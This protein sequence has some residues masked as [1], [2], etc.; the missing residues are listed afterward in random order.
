ALHAG[1][2]G[3]GVALRGANRWLPR[4]AGAAVGL[5]GLALLG[6]LA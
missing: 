5:F 4:A 3:L 1:G 2:I 6:G